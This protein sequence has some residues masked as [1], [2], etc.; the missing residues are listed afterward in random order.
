MKVLVVQETDW[1]E[2]NPILH[3]RML[4]SMA[5]AGDAVLVLDHD[6]LWGTKGRHPIVQRRRE[7]HDVTKFYAGSGVRVIRPAMLRIRGLARPSWLAA[8]TIELI[9]AFRGFKPDVVVAYGLSNAFVARALAGWYRVPFVFHIFDALHAI[10]EPSYLA[11]IARLVEQAVLRSADEVIVV[12]RALLGYVREMGVRRARI[13]FIMNGF[14]V[15]E[16][17]EGRSR[18]VRARHGIAEDEVMIL[19]IGWLYTHSGLME[20]ARS[21]AE[22]DRFA[23][24]RLVIAGDGDLLPDLRELARS[25]EHGDRIVVLGKLP[26][27]QI[28]DLIGAADVGLCSSVPDPAMRYVVPAKVD[29]YL[30]MGRPVLATRLPGLLAEL[31][32]VGSV[33]WI[34]GP[35]AALETLDAA[36]AGHGDRR[37]F[38][39]QLGNQARDYGKGRETWEVVTR[40]FRAVLA[41]ARRR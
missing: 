3:H 8:T 20:V 16:A 25:G 14:T 13:H 11:P 32:S 6:I 40:R 34:D 29:E 28:P 18:E 5:L 26:V 37:A 15:R 27:G 41:G 35:Q 12:H 33:I 4:E 7:H 1:I 9:R 31:A 30:E 22:S 21:L 17:D 2:R 36:L 23:G 19:F 38:L 10:A 24:Y 39:G